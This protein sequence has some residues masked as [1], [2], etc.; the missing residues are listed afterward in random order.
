MRRT[1]MFVFIYVY[2]NLETNV[3]TYLKFKKSISFPV[4]SSSA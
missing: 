3:H 2:R 4:F 1:Y